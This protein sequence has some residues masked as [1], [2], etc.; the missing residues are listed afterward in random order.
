MS[1]FNLKKTESGFAKIT[2]LNNQLQIRQFLQIS[3]ETLLKENK[4]AF[5]CLQEAAFLKH[6]PFTVS[7][8]IA[9]M[10]NSISR[11]FA[12]TRCRDNI[13]TAASL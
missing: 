9:L 8:Q 1:Y 10:R 5:L 11:F 2:G 6:I 12:K 4:T 13:L 7:K 3:E